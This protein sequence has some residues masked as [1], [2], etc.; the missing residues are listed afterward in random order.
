MI[1]KKQAEMYC[2]EP[3]E[4]IEN[5]EKAIADTER[6]WCCHHVWETMLGYSKE[7]LIE[8]NEYYGIP[9]CNLIFL[10]RSEHTRIH[11]ILRTGEKN[12]FY[13]KTQTEEG[14]RKL[15]ESHKGIKQSLESKQKKRIVMR[16][17]KNMSKPVIQYTINGE[18]VKEWPSL[19]EITRVCGFDFKN[20]SACCL[21]KKKT[22]HKYIWKYKEN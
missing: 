14:R 11:A 1:N 20:I 8:M 9:A 12:P 22:S 13:G 7:E 2:A 5:Y 19:H 4:K 6:V 18:F 10:T 16:N 15:S 21:G 17:H 3:I